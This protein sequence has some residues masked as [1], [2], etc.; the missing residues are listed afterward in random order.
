M[1][2]FIA[3]IATLC[4]LANALYLRAAETKT[5]SNWIS[6]GLFIPKTNLVVGDRILASM[7]CSNSTEMG[8][9]LYGAHGD[10]CGTGFGEFWI[11][12]TTS[13]D[14]V[15]CRFKDRMP[16]SYQLDLLE[17]H[18]E[19]GFSFDLRDVYHLTNT[20][21]YAIQA[22][23]RFTTN[24]LKEKPDHYFSVVTPPIIISLSP[25]VETNVPPK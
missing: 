11:T 6:F 7:I 15:Q 4:F 19:R 21:V 16:Y 3:G 25:K 12:E 13:G 2:H 24:N 18:T 5:N 14:K 10:P 1:K 8:H 17:G 9:Y 22:S 23:G 20:G